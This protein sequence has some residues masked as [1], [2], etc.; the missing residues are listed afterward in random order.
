MKIQTE[1]LVADTRSQMDGQTNGGGLHI[2]RLFLLYKERL[3]F[4]KNTSYNITACERTA[5]PGT[6]SADVRSVDGN[7]R[8]YSV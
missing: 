3:R 6:C 2:S 1:N 4:K 8:E 5:C 7:A